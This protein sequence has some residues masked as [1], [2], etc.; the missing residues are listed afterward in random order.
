MLKSHVSPGFHVFNTWV[1]GLW[2]FVNYQTQ[3][4]GLVSFINNQTHH[5]L[6]P[7]LLVHSTYTTYIA[8][9]DDIYDIK[10]PCLPCCHVIVSSHV[11]AMHQSGI[12]RWRNSLQRGLI[13]FFICITSIA[14]GLVET[15]SPNAHMLGCLVRSSCTSCDAQRV[16]ATTWTI[17]LLFYCRMVDCEKPERICACRVQPLPLPRFEPWSS[18]FSGPR[19]YL[20]RKTACPFRVSR[21]YHG[22]TGLH[23]DRA[24]RWLGQEQQG[25]HV[26][27]HL[28]SKSCNCCPSCTLW[29][30]SEGG[31]HFLHKTDKFKSTC[32]MFQ[33][34]MSN[35]WSFGSN[36]SN[37]WSV[38]KVMSVDR[39][40]IQL[41]RYSTFIMAIGKRA[42]QASQAKT[43]QIYTPYRLFWSRRTPSIPDIKSAI[44]CIWGIRTL[45]SSWTHGV[46]CVHLM[47]HFGQDNMWIR[48]Y[49][50]LASHVLSN[51]TIRAN[52]NKQFA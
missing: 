1:I 22:R 52:I 47:H 33:H 7:L 4:C 41:P 8:I 38:M 27:I 39:I 46:V 11:V 28:G 29:G 9:T 3:F 23:F 19:H 32:T 43:L 2:A 36:L 25:R 50:W 24:S 12:F 6:L 20:H 10:K 17:N 31:H 44:T 5:P 51:K 30:R 49:T 35:A 14:T 48:G 21:R 15:D 26:I 42:S 40:S 13:S 34:L 18:Q 37:D 16:C 45:Y